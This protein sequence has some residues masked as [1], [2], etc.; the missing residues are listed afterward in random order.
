[1]DVIVISK[2]RLKVFIV[3]IKEKEGSD[4]LRVFAE[5]FKGRQLDI[6]GRHA[7]KCM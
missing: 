7:I 6:I 4:S 3:M 2:G 5:F 1:M